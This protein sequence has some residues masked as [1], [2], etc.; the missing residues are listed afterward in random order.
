MPWVIVVRHLRVTGGIV[1]LAPR[2]KG[3]GELVD[4]RTGVAEGTPVPWVDH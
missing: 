3:D 1:H 2:V 4:Y